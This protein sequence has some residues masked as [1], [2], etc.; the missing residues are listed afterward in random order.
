ME[1]EIFLTINYYFQLIKKLLINLNN[2]REK[3]V[4]IF[5]SI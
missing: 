1:T 5:K 3:N 2:F 4:K